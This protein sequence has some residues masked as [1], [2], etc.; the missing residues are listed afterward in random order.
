MVKKESV[1]VK[2]A[3]IS[4]ACVLAISGA[5]IVLEAHQYYQSVPV[6]SFYEQGSYSVGD[7]IMPDQLYNNSTVL[8]DPST[9]YTS[10]TSSVN[11]T[12]QLSIS[13]DNMSSRDITLVNVVTLKSGNPGW[14]KVVYTNVTS[15]PV[16]GNG[17]IDVPIA[18][19]FSKE[20]ALAYSI[21]TQLQGSTSS[22]SLDFNMTGESSGQT[23]IHASIQIILHST[24]YSVSYKVPSPVSSTQYSKELIVPHNFIGL[25]KNFGYVLIGGAGSLA[26]LAAYLYIPRTVDTLARLKKQY[27]DQ[28]IEITK[29]IGE[30]A[31]K[32]KSPEDLFRISE[33]FEVPVFL[34]TPDRV[35]YLNHLNAQYFYEVP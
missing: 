1:W 34:N 28:L 29:P 22:V 23:P 19:N 3:I 24:F 11:I 5:I 10:I 26:A 8:I 6:S 2:A 16:S 18:V 25:G 13:M 17:K 15:A 12:S 4:V 20:L 9:I 7:H 27:G 21:D 35:I 32:V 31:I 14:S 30:G 33:I